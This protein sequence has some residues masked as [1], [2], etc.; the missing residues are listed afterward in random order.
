[1]R[2]FVD[3]CPLQTP[4]RDRGIG[5]YTAGLLSGLAAVRP[6]WDIEVIEH[7]NL[8]AIPREV[9]AGLTLRPFDCPFPY[10]L[11]Q[12]M[13]FVAADHYY[14]DWLVAERPDHV[15][16]ASVFEKLGV[17]PSFT[18]LRVPMSAIVYDFIP[19]IFPEHYGLK[20]GTEP[21]YVRRYQDTAQMD[22]L[23]A[24]SDATAIDARRLVGPGGPPVTNVKG[25]VS[26]TFRPLT[27]DELSRAG[28]EVSERLRIGGPFLL[29][30][31]GEDHRKN[32]L[33]ALAGYGA[34]PREL[35]DA[36]QLVIAC[37]LPDAQVS[38]VRAAATRLGI[39]NR[40]VLTGF[41]SDA[42]LLVLYQTCRLLFFPSLYEGLG[43]PVLEA[44]TCGAPVACANGSSLPEFAGDV[45][46]FFD[47]D[48]PADM[49]RA[50][51]ACLA[52]PRDT[53]HSSR[54][55]FARSHTWERT[56]EAVATGITTTKT[57]SRLPRLASLLKPGATSYLPTPTRWD[58]VEVSADT[59]LR[60]P[61][62][63]QLELNWNDPPPYADPGQF[64]LTLV[65]LEDNPTPSVAAVVARYPTL[66]VLRGKR[67]DYRRATLRPTLEQ[68][69]AVLVHSTEMHAWVRSITDTPVVT[70][71]PNGGT[72]DGLALEVLVDEL[73][74]ATTL[75]Q[76][77]WINRTANALEAV[78]LD[79]ESVRE[80]W[81]ALRSA[82]PRSDH[83]GPV[84]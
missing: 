63:R 43:L 36:Y 61:D 82:S 65:E 69:T 46:W 76:R 26:T 56:A 64:D 25:A 22:R 62:G 3:G 40:L 2:L 6:D 80:Q 1:M 77:G 5:R 71:P 12:P 35:R 70:I 51:L 38:E 53:R 32:L 29:Y 39:A 31:G 8:P 52:E 57:R 74:T 41:I 28:P 14:A 44:L 20:T 42:D 75:S 67:R 73:L 45:S 55:E 21:W 48:D 34:L 24:I 10:D 9:V 7:S 84:S 58:V 81:A 11:A 16:F 37:Y 54:A 18:D 4:A 13:N 30:V 33:G 83:R 79:S 47:P 59:L 72:V 17:V 78:A 68:A 49:A 66:L 27:E 15:L 60:D 19:L 50:L 23:F